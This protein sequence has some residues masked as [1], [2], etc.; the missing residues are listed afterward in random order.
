MARSDASEDDMDEP[1]PVGFSDVDG[2]A[3]PDHMLNAMDVT[4][5]WPAVQA[6]HA[7]T[8]PFLTGHDAVLEVGCGLGGALMTIAA[9]NPAGRYVGIDLSENMVAEARRSANEVGVAAE[10]RTGDA[11][12]LDFADDEFDAVR[13][14]RVLQ[15]LPDPQA[16]V[17]E[18]IRVTRPG[19][20]I[21]LL[22]TDW[23]T[24]GSTLD[25]ELMHRV[26]AIGAPQPAPHAGGFLRYWLTTLGA[27]AVEARAEVHHATTWAGDGTDGL[28]PD[29]V[30][31]EGR[32]ARGVDPADAEAATRGLHEQSD[33]ATLSIVLTMWAATGTVPRT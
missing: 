2:A 33:A 26:N 15:W 20:R 1:L 6:L 14:E 9:A 27:E 5:R 19:G 21:V 7:W 22:D 11:T 30:M 24:L 16:A 31:T 18:M 17:A 12:V 28:P 4:A 10:F 13:A 25:P 32:I 3:D 29:H 8:M 23:R